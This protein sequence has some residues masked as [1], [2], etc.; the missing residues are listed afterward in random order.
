MEG[1]FPAKNSVENNFKCLVKR[2]VEHYLKNYDAFVFIALIENDP[3]VSEEAL[4]AGMAELKD[5]MLVIK[6][7]QK[8]GKLKNLDNDLFS[9]LV[10]CNITAIIRYL[11]KN[12]KKKVNPKILDIVWDT[13]RK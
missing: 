13:V 7:W 6:D 8:T 4:Q 1:A 5:L 12:K 9:T 10:W 3:Q 11:R 2:S